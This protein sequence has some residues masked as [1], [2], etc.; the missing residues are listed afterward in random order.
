MKKILLAFLLLLFTIPLASAQSVNIGDYSTVV[1]SEV[2]VPI[3]ISEAESIAGGVVNISFSSSI[4][5]IDDVLAGDFGTPV[6]NVNN[7]NGWVK[8]VAARIDAVN[9][10]QAVLANIVFNGSSNGTS[11][12]T[13]E[14]ASLNNETGALITPLT[15]NGKIVVS[16]SLDDISPPSSIRDLV[17]YS[18]SSWINWTWTNPSDSDFNH[19]MVYLEGKF[20]DNISDQYFN[21]TNL[22]QGTIHTISTHTV[23]INGNINETWVNDTAKTTGVLSGGL[24][25]T[26]NKP[27]NYS[28]YSVGEQVRFDVNVTD[29]DNN[30]ISSGFSAYVE[31][32]APNNISKHINLSEESGHFVGGYTVDNNDPRGLWL[33]N[34]TVY[35]STSSGLTSFKVFFTGAYFIQPYSNSHSYL[36]GESANFTAKVMK[37]GN[38]AQYLSDENVSLNLSIYPYNSSTP[39]LESIEMVYD[40]NSHLFSID[41][42]TDLIGPGLFTVLFIGN[43]TSGNIEAASLLIGVSEDYAIEVSTEKRNYDRDNPVNISGNVKYL[44]NSPLSNVNVNLLLNLHGFKRSYVVN[45][46]EIGEF[47]YTFH[48]FDTEAGN[49]TLRATAANMGLLRIAENS[50]TIHGLY[51]VPQSAI[52]ELVENSSRTISFTLYNIGD[53][54]LT[55]I[56]TSVNDLNISDNVIATIDPLS[57]PSELQPYESASFNLQI[58]AGTPVPDE[59]VFQIEVTTDQMSN[60]ISDLDVKLFSPTP[61]LKIYPEDVLVGLNKNQTAIRTVGIYN[62]GYGILKNVTLHQPENSW[63]RITSNTSIGDLLPGENATFE[64]HINSYNVDLGVY[65]DS[66]NITSDNF[67]EVQVNLTAFVTDLQNGR[68]LFH[69]TDALERNLSNANIS[70]INQDT[71]EEFDGATNSTG[72]TLMNN[73]PVGRYIF[74]V[75]SDGTNTLP[76]MGNV[77]V[78]AMDTPKLMEISL[79][80]SFIDFDWEV[81]PTSIEDY[82]NVI[83][84]MRFETDV[85]IPLLLAFPPSIDY[86][87]IPGEEKTGSFKIYNVGLVSIYNVSISSI[88]HNSFVLEPLITNVDEINGKSSINVPYKIRLSSDASNCQRLYGKINIQ[89]RYVHFI[90]NHEVISYARTSIPVSVK[91]PVDGSCI[92]DSPD[93]PDI[94]FCLNID[95]IHLGT[96][97]ENLSVDPNIIWLKTGMEWGNLIEDKSEPIEGAAIATNHNEIGDIRLSDAIGITISIGVNEIVSYFTM[98]TLTP[99]IP[100]GIDLVTDGLGV[101][102]PFFDKFWVGD[103]TPNAIA[104]DQSSTMDLES[105]NTGVGVPLPELIGGGLIFEYGDLD[106]Y[107]CFWLIPIGGYDLTLPT[108]GLPDINIHFP[109]V[110]LGRGGGTVGGGSIGDGTFCWDCVPDIFI[111]PSRPHFG[112]ITYVPWDWPEWNWPDFSSD[113]VYRKPRPRVTETIHEIIE[114]SISQNVTM[115]RDAFWAGLGIFN[116]MPDKNIDNVMVTLHIKDDTGSANDKFFIKAPHLKGISNIDGSGIIYPSGL[117]TSQWLIIP[118]PGAS[119][120]NP[121]GARYNISANITYSVDGINFETVTHEIEIFVKPQP[122]MVLDY[123]IPSDVIANKPF[124]LAVKVTNDGYGEA[125]DFAIET[126]QPV[127][128]YNPSGLLIDFEIIRS[129]LQGEERSTSMKVDFGDVQPG[130]SKIAWWDMVTS[131]DGTFTQFTGEYTHSSELGGMETSLIKELN[132]YI[133]Q[134]QLG[135]GELGYDFLANSESDENYYVLFNSSTGSST[136]VN[137]ANYAV[138]NMPTPENPVLDVSIEDYTGDWVIVSLEDPY[139]NGIQ[140]EKVIRTSDGS[141]IPSYNYWMRDGRILI[142]DHYVEGFD[143]KYTIIFDLPGSS[144]TRTPVEYGSFTLYSFDYNNPPRSDYMIVVSPLLAQAFVAEEMGSQDEIDKKADQIEEALR[145]VLEKHENMNPYILFVDNELGYE[146]DVKKLRKD[147]Y[148]LP[149]VHEGGQ[150]AGDIKTYKEI[151]GESIEPTKEVW[152]K[153]S[154]VVIREVTTRNNKPKYV[155]ILGSAQEFPEYKIFRF[156]HYYPVKEFP[157]FGHPSLCGYDVF[158]DSHYAY[159]K[160]FWHEKYMAPIGRL[161]LQFVYNYSNSDHSFN[162]KAWIH[163]SESIAIEVMGIPIGYINYMENFQK[164]IYESLYKKDYDEVICTA[165]KEDYKYEMNATLENTSLFVA[166]WHGSTR[167]VCAHGGKLNISN[168]H[169]LIF[170]STSCLGSNTGDYNLTTTMELGNPD[171]L[172]SSE[173]LS[174]SASYVGNTGYGDGKEA[175]EIVNK[176]IENLVSEKVDKTTLGDSWLQTIKEFKGSKYTRDQFRLLGDPALDTSALDDT[177]ENHI[178]TLP[179]QFSINISASYNETLINGDS[180]FNLSLSANSSQNIIYSLTE[181]QFATGTGAPMVPTIYIDIP[182]PVNQT[183]DNVTVVFDDS[184]TTSIN[185]TE[186]VS[187]LLT[188]DGAEVI[189][190]IEIHGDYPPVNFTYSLVTVPDERLLKIQAIPVEYNIDSQIAKLYRSIN[191]TVHTKPFVEENVTAKVHIDP[192]LDYLALHQDEN[193]SL[194]ISLYNDYSATENATNVSVTAEIPDDLEIISASGTING[195][196][197]GHNVTWDVNNLT[198]A[199]VNSFK[200]VELVIQAPASIPDMAIE[201]INLTATYSNESGGVYEPTEVP[202]RVSL[203]PPDYVD[204]TVSNMVIHRPLKLGTPTNV[205]AVISNDGDIGITYVPVRLLIDGNES[206]GLIIDTPAMESQSVNL[207][208][209]GLTP[210]KHQIA[211]IVQPISIETNIT[212]N[213]A[214]EDVDIYFAMLPPLSTADPYNLSYGSTLPIRFAV[215]DNGTSEFISD[216]TVNV[217]ILNSTNHIITSFNATSGVLID[218][219]EAH[220]AVDLDTLNYPELT[221]GETYAVSVT[222][223]ADDALLSYATAHFTL[224]EDLTPPCSITDLHPTAATTWLNW[225]WTNPSDPDFN[226]TEIYLDGVFQTIVSAEYFNA[227]D[228]TTDTNYTISTRTVDTAGNI[229]QTWVNNTTTTLPASDTNPPI[230][231]ITSPVSGTTYST[232][233]VNLNYSVNE[234]TT[235]QGYSLDGAANITLHGNTTLTGFADGLHILAVSAN[236]TSGNMNSSTVCFTIATTT[237]AVNTVTLNTTTPNTGDS[238]MVTVNATDDVAVISV[239]ANDVVLPHQSGDMWTG[240]ITAI[241]GIHYVNVSATDAAGNVGWNNSTSYTATTPDTI[242][243]AAIANLHPTAGTTYL[244]WT[245]TN[246]PDPDFNHTEIYLNGT[247]Q[248]LTSA[249]FFNATGMIPNTEYEIS[250]RTGDNLGNINETWVNDTTMTLDTPPVSNASGPYTGI[251]GQAIIFNASASYDPDPG[252]NIVSF[253]WDF[254]ND[255]ATDATGMEVIWTWNDDHTGQVNLTVIDSYGESNTNTTS[256]TILN[257]PPEVE[258][259]NDQ[260]VNEGDI[261]SFAGS[262]TDPGTADTHLIEWD[263]GDGTPISSGTLTPAH[264]YADNGTYTVNLTITDD[265]GAST[266]DTLIVTINNVV[267]VLDEC[268]DQTVQWGNTMTFSRSFTDPGDDSWTAEIDWGDDSQEEGILSSKIIT[269]TH[270]YSIPGEYI[271]TLT[272]QDDD[273]GVGSGNMHVTVTTRATELEYIGD[274]SAQYSDYIDLKAQLNDSGNNNPLPDKSINFILSTQTAT[275]TT[276]PDG[277]ATTSFKLDQPAGSYDIKTEFTGDDSYSPDN[278]TKAMQISR[279]DAEITYTGDTILPTTAGSI[280]LRAT[281]EE[282]DTD[283]GDLTKINVNFTIYKGS[284]LSYSNPI[285]I[286]PSIASISVTSSGMGVGTATATIDNLPEED[287]MII[288]RIVP[289]DYYLPISSN[290]TPMIVYEPIGQFTTGGGWIWDPTGSHG[291]FGFNVKYNKKGKVKGNSIYVYRL[292]GLDYIV[293]SNAWIGL[294]INDNTSTFQGKA[295]LQIFDPVTGELQPESSGNFQFTVEAMDNE[296]NGNPDNYKITVLDKDGLEYHNATGSLKGGNIVIHDK[297][298]R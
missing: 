262:F 204:L 228:L 184:Y 15:S 143:G 239:A 91:T 229:N 210:G 107:N 285:A 118:K 146:S 294:A 62:R 276:G 275:A 247:F 81:T 63:I 14:Y 54:T 185:L 75:S 219:D 27:V 147:V 144:L 277:I 298:S 23:D 19:T 157:D 136:F 51:I 113:P 141:E 61:I 212:N 24:H 220:Y 78:E 190:G 17:S 137:N 235:W 165:K 66:V 172:F 31:L 191:V 98:G 290:P 161:P 265:D 67:N 35:N 203:I 178:S 197:D 195:T 79:Y 169:P 151:T 93:W 7:T 253:E 26:L 234:P 222:F 9:K 145:A 25:V 280:D 49:Y 215:T 28:I 124:K 102:I 189:P 52:V 5:S 3:N 74:V 291:N 6:A 48:P 95:G 282:I 39:V 117:A 73:L 153:Y 287:Y 182:M 121:E 36:L 251:E 83:L 32:S 187:I 70:L 84:K 112:G 18:G 241:A 156:Q 205:T 119:G 193:T 268:A 260:T 174:N 45:T 85:P 59:A 127:I 150:N 90:N 58:E 12:L 126:A 46:N 140:I 207:S 288:A 198:T 133:I 214:T 186:Y 183:I 270:V 249:E 261:I 10:N 92:I 168:V 254:D 232:D 8:L 16:L 286:I 106:H 21:A 269:A 233:P 41:V 176:F 266:L 50:F 208:I 284:D 149:F 271:C 76:Q 160:Q 226:H 148:G 231:T 200:S 289:N 278:D 129:Q 167:K 154:N 111:P 250:T 292:D 194:I 252:D 223:G 89:G 114:L 238:I 65:F 224:E 152:K 42:G 57:V 134:K 71:Y 122:E 13:I 128:Y 257:A 29:S 216:N 103:F 64:I 175:P 101:N 264:T 209:G 37:P 173:L 218:S 196:I 105:L 273:G 163:N 138:V 171:E 202:I 125:R 281:L 55:S 22:I 33:G 159:Q 244:N 297:K 68:L 1:D 56:S 258:A 108:F 123:F 245:W 255:G 256:V 166:G 180:L 181:D 272:V 69:V 4:V 97:T 72:Y 217:S 237:P 20:V 80:M 60:E 221:L 170:A 227:T 87:M 100:V 77:E 130:E 283:Y 177:I 236:D 274:L 267:P 34:I 135:T 192:S 53:T 158:S 155:L 179:L 293:K 295:V 88:K 243:P 230:I 201:Q 96:R 115:E 142:V 296:L 211:T 11:A 44:N 188:P 30:P 132:T 2:I 162:K 38:P 240:T 120:I 279:E 82:Y 116:K 225:T 110:H 139:N 99:Q 43:D 263:F 47:N 86:N 246:P 94:P 206:S 40:N 104:P 109:H 131:I 164:P 248:T 213:I 242:P 259:G 199:G